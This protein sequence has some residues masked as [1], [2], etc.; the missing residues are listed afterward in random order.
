M[1][2]KPQNAEV[3]FTYVCPHCQSTFLKTIK[4][5]KYVGKEVC[6]CGRILEFQYMDYVTVIPQYTIKQIVSPI[7][8]S[9]VSY[10]TKPK[11]NMDW[12]LGLINIGYKKP[13][14]VALVNTFI[15][16]K[17]YNEKLTAD[18]LFVKILQQVKE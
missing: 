11:S 2:L 10:N 18:E 5:V 8:T 12:V 4:E 7:Q 16:S 9:R 6:Y 14:A 13:Q 3:Y 15:Q 17:D 1:K